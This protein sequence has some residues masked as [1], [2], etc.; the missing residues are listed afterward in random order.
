MMQNLTG[1][2]LWCSPAAFLACLVLVIRS[3]RVQTK[4][5]R[6]L[7]ALAREARR[8]DEEVA[9]LVS[10]RLPALTAQLV[11]PPSDF[12]APL[13]ESLIGTQF[14]ASLDAV[15]MLF[16]R[17]VQE[18]RDK[19]EKTAHTV[20]RSA[21]CSLEE[22]VS[23]QQ[24]LLTATRSGNHILQ[25]PDE[26]VSDIEQIN[27]QV[28]RRIQNI[29]ILAGAGIGHNHQPTTLTDVIHAARERT[30]HCKRLKFRDPTD[31]TV[32]ADAVEPL[33]IAIA[34]LLDN[35]GRQSDPAIPISV[36]IHTGQQGTTLTI[37]DAG[38][39]MDANLLQQASAFLNGEQSTA[40]CRVGR[41]N[42][43]G[44]AVVGLLAARYDFRALLGSRS[45]LGGAR[46]MLVLPVTLTVAETAEEPESASGSRVVY[47]SPF[48]ADNLAGP[49]GRLLHTS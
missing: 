24:E 26:L 8:R 16:A 5:A 6:E 7:S 15:G 36:G 33:I 48:S 28:G 45:P 42:Q 9:Y 20:V 13:H 18:A 29:G 32:V 43:F 31:V 22:L 17:T 10:S 23:E 14:H 25:I 41:P 1:A 11:G 21:M 49:T 35:G 30:Q 38:T 44:L 3:R 47:S 4:L 46:A 34:E 27:A 2:L 19:A 40:L 12:P 37:D 39:G